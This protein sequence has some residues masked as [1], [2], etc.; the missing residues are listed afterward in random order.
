VPQFSV[1]CV[2]YRGGTSR[3]LFFHHKDLPHDQNLQKIIFLSGIDAYN[4]SQIDGLGSGTS[5][6]SKVVVIAP[7]QE[8]GVDV[9]YTFVQ[10][11]IGEPVADSKGTCG[12]LMAAVGAFAVDEGLVR[13]PFAGTGQVVVSVFDTNIRKRLRLTVPVED[14]KAKTGGDYLMPGVVRPGAKYSVNILNPGGGKTG[15]T[16]PLGATYPLETLAKTY[17][18]TFVDIVNPIIFISARS[19]G[20]EGTE[21]NSELG[22][23]QA[24]LAELENIRRAGAV[25]AG[26]AENLEAAALSQ[27]IPKIALVSE[28][29]D[30]LTPS[31]RLIKAE[32]VDIVAKMLSMGRV[33]RTFTGSG[34][35]ALAAALLLQGT[36]PNRLG[37]A[38]PGTQEQLIRIGHAEGVVEVRVSLTKNGKDIA[39]VGMDRSVRRIMKGELFIPGAVEMASARL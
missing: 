29:R 17:Q 8:P 5:H 21:P 6:T 1:P 26:M 16:L 18:A 14:G 2:V 35:Y 32:E 9:N 3:G 28:P 4:P 19:L 37:T 20:L 22:L 34:L 36:I 25:A 23:N 31:N 30:Y 15:Q 10:V 27:A 39:S 11:G 24:L 33:H 38:N 7:S 13:V 12:N